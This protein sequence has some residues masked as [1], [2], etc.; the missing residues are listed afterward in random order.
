VTHLAT[1]GVTGRPTAALLPNSRFENK[2]LLT[3]AAAE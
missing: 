3:F 2:E 1:P